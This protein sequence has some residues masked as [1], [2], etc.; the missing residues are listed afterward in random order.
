MKSIV[1]KILKTEPLGFG[2]GRIVFTYSENTVIKLPLVYKDEFNPLKTFQ[3]YE[4]REREKLLQNIVELMVYKECPIELKYL[5]CPIVHYFYI[6][7]IPVIIS[8]G[9]SGLK[10]Y[11]ELLD[12]KMR[13]SAFLSKP[14][15]MKEL[16]K[17]VKENL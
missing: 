13:P 15:K 9:K 5:L 6:Q 16:V 10:E 1:E 7:D 17:T 12:E 14:Y 4:K 11:F 2:A 8:S 3:E